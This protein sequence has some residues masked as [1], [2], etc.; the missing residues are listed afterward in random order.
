MEEGLETLHLF[1]ELNP[2]LIFHYPTRISSFK[3]NLPFQVSSGPFS[4]KPRSSMILGGIRKE[5]SMGSEGRWFSRPPA[6][7]IS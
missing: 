6:I 2:Y 1:M 7:F 3:I 5:A 4:E